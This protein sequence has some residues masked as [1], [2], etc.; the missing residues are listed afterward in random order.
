MLGDLCPSC[1]CGSYSPDL[2][3]THLHICYATC[4]CVITVVI[5]SHPMN[6][7]LCLTQGN[8]A[9]F[10]CV[11]DPMGLSITNVRWFILD[12][13]IFLSTGG[14]PGHSDETFS[15]SSSVVTSV[16]RVFNVT[17]NDNGAEYQCSPVHD[18]D[19]NSAFLTVL[20]KIIINS[21]INTYKYLH[22]YVCDCILACV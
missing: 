15:N 20:G 21:S 3:N 10:T 19:S 17:M 22:M 12:S 4:I 2:L 8:T 11:A 14:R 18:V 7:T 6:M 9:I 5:T 13:G 1:P 16:L